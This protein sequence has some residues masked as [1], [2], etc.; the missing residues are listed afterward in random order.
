[1]KN[2]IIIVACLFFTGCASTQTQIPAE[3][4]RSLYAE[5]DLAYQNNEHQKALKIYIKLSSQL[6]SDATLWFKIGNSYARLDKQSQAIEAYEKAVVIDPYLSKAWH[7]IGVIQLK[8][9]VNTWLQML[10][11]IPKNDPLH[12]KAVNLSKNL[13]ALNSDESLNSGGDTA[14]MPALTANVVPSR[15]VAPF[16]VSNVVPDTVSSTA[17]NDLVQKPN[18]VSAAT[19]IFEASQRLTSSAESLSGLLTKSIGQTERTAIFRELSQLW[20]VTLPQKNTPLSCGDVASAGLN[21]LSVGEW[22]QLV[23]YNRPAILVLKYEGQYHRV[24]LSE[25]SSKTSVVTFNNRSYTVNND[26]LKQYWNGS[27]VIFTRPNNIG[28]PL[29]QVGSRNQQVV[30]LRQKL[31]LAIDIAK[32]PLLSSE[33]SLLF[34]ED[35]STKLARLQFTYGLINDG[36]AGQETYLLI[37]ELLHPQ[38]TPVLR[39]R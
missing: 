21:C 2:Y 30:W 3:E 22:P 16:T 34:D 28:S 10:I 11:Y 38:K 4:V 5:G 36:K 9:S 12:A 14:V 31:N 32:L 24:I 29:L 19:E 7:N 39:S 33:S 8:Q 13:I 26:E 20:G 6:P 17:P 25:I 18:Q 37:N 23:R 15:V 27:S 35:M 1:M